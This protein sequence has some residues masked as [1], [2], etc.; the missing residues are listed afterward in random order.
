MALAAETKLGHYGKGGMG[1]VYRAADRKL[2]RDV[3]IK[4]LPGELAEDEERLRRPT[5]N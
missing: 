1:E 3:A 2:G 5:D 4:V